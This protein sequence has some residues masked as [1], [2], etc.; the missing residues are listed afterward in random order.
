MVQV[1]GVARPVQ[2]R[3]ALSTST[4]QRA[5]SDFSADVLRLNK[6]PT[7]ARSV[8]SKFIVYGK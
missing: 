8:Q 2:Q 6:M 4:R 7:T 5:G 3:I 1:G